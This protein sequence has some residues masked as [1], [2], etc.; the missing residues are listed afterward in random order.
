MV[1]ARPSASPASCACRK[2]EIGEAHP[3]P[4]ATA[5]VQPMFVHVH[6]RRIP[7]HRAEPGG[8]AA[9]LRALQ[10]K[11]TFRHDRTVLSP[12]VRPDLRRQVS[13]LRERRKRAL[14]ALQIRRNVFRGRRCGQRVAF[15]ASLPEPTVGRRCFH[16]KKLTVF[17]H[18]SSDR[19]QASA[20]NNRRRG[21]WKRVRG[22]IAVS[23]RKLHA[24][25]PVA[26]TRPRRS[27]VAVHFCAVA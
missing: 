3:S 21:N 6:E 16:G 20:A 27:D 14:G 8:A 25:M 7:S 11:L 13:Q 22:E 17:R 10:S 2:R 9:P 18:K 4:L 19:L 1:P 15:A 23:S 5:T 12:F 24:W 26:S